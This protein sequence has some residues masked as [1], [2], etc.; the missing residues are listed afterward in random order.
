[1]SCKMCPL[2]KRRHARPATQNLVPR[3]NRVPRPHHPYKLMYSTPG[4]A[5]KEGS[6]YFLQSRYTYTS[7]H[8]TDMN[9][10]RR[11]YEEHSISENVFVR[12]LTACTTRSN[13]RWTQDGR[14]HARHHSAPNRMKGTLDSECLWNCGFRWEPRETSWLLEGMVSIRVHDVLNI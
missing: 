8:V 9:L 1:M 14:L 6:V 2:V 11:F 13:V 7:V 10:L 3:E 12:R 4:S 5:W